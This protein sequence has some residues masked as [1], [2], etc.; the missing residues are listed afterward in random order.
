MLATHNVPKTLTPII[1]QRAIDDRTM[2][3]SL[4]ISKLKWSYFSVV[5]TRLQKAGC[6]I[7]A[8]PKGT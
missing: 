4:D 2:L 6:G 3:T 8:P 7:V 5:V 1:A